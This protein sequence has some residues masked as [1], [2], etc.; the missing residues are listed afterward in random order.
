MQGQMIM[1]ME[2]M[3]SFDELFLKYGVGEEDISRGFRENKLDG[4]PEFIQ[5]IQ[6]VQMRLQ[7]M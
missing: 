2:K 7:S 5:M 6:A 1:E 4:D 3:R